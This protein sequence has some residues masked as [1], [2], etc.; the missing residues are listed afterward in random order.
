MLVVAAVKVAHQDLVVLAVGEQ[1]L[2]VVQVFL[3]LILLEVEGVLLE[4]HPAAT[5]VPE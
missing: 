5:V 1:D 2:Q 4:V 3:E